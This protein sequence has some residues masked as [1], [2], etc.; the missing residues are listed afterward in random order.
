METKKCSKCGEVKPIS[1]CHK[2][3][4]SNDG[5]NWRCKSCRNELNKKW[6]RKNKQVVRERMKK[7]RLVNKEKCREIS[8]KWRQKNIL[9]VRKKESERQRERYKKNKNNP[10]YI[11]NKKIS[12]LIRQSLR[13]NKN[14]W[15]WEDLVGYTLEDLI[16]HLENQFVDNMTWDNYGEWHIDHIRPIASFNFTSHKDKEFKECWALGNLQPLWAE[17]NLRKSNRYTG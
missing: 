13:G 4:I 12:N 15:H 16:T 5:Y 7:W 3:K 6:Y 10:N 9:D 1:E 17:K 2:S 11:L 8:K 14:G